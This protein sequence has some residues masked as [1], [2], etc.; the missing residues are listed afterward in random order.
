ML[1]KKSAVSC[2]VDFEEKTASFGWEPDVAC[3]GSFLSLK[4]AVHPEKLLSA[5]LLAFTDF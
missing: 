2:Q 3:L 4:V 5:E 1:N